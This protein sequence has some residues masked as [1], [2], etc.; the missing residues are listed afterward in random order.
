VCAVAG[1]RTDACG[2]LLAHAGAKR[3]RHTAPADA[4][5]PVFERR[6]SAAHDTRARDAVAHEA[7]AVLRRVCCVRGD[8]H[9]ERALLGVL[10]R[11]LLRRASVV[12]L[13]EL[14]ELNFGTTSSSSSSAS[15]ASVPG[16][17][18]LVT[19]ASP[20]RVSD[21]IA[22]PASSANA[23]GD[24]RLFAWLTMR[25]DAAG[26]GP[27]RRL[28]VWLS[29]APLLLDVLLL[30]AQCA[31]DCQ[32]RGMRALFAALLATAGR[33]DAVT[34]RRELQ[35]LTAL[36]QRV[37]WLPTPLA[38]AVDSVPI[39]D[40]AALRRMVDAGACVRVCVCRALTTS[41]SEC[42]DWRAAVFGCGDAQCAR[43]AAAAAARC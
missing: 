20:G 13:L 25:G 19:P 21:A 4:S 29:E 35:Q 8:T 3:R 22:L 27:L 37:T 18:A 32:Q 1:A 34:S 10:R 11:A 7:L 38:I 2:S 9:V 30:L 23:S 14:P 26:V 6:G 12:A 31:S 5:L 17:P 39:D 40:V 33:G 16:T 28:R 41:A 15:G 24:E 42:C 36:A 43:R